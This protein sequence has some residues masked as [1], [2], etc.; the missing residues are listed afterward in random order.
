[1]GTGHFM[2]WGG[3]FTWIIW[4]LLFALVA[5][6]VAVLVRRPGGTGNRARE[7][8]DKRYAN[9]EINRETYERIKHDLDE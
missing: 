7:Q 5:W 8:L 2:G 3:P 6:L 1:M 9:G 4:L